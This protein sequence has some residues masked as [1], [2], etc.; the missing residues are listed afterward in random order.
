MVMGISTLYGDLGV[1]NAMITIVPAA[2]LLLLGVVL[3]MFK[4]RQEI[5]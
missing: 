4:A 1:G 2:I 3:G 5:R